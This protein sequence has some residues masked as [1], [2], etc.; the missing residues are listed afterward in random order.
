[1]QPKR[2]GHSLHGPTLQAVMPGQPDRASVI[3][4]MVPSAAQN[5]HAFGQCIHASS[6]TSLRTHIFVSHWAV[7]T[8]GGRIKTI[9]TKHAL[10]VTHCLRICLSTLHQNQVPDMHTVCAWCCM[11]CQPERLA[12]QICQAPLRQA[13]PPLLSQPLDR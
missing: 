6:A 7:S 9:A 4:G 2:E 1:V 5:V 10:S 11:Q 3:P 8:A 13:G 12:I